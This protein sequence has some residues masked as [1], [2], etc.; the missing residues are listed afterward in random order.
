S[1]CRQV[2]HHEQ[3]I[4]DAFQV[5]CLVFAAK[6]ASIQ[7]TTSVASWLYGVAYR[8]AMNAK[9]AR[10]RRGEEQREVEGST[11]RQPVTEAALREVQTILA[12]EVNALPE[13]YRTPFVLC[14]LD[15]N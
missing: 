8:T 4:D 1:V 11:T 14:C 2:L 3:D 5:T 10:T 13:K 6:A 7:R 15:G 12:D 9:R